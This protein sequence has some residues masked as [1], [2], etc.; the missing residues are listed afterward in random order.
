MQPGKAGRTWR[1][2][3]LSTP[4]ASSSK[5]QGPVAPHF[6]ATLNSSS[7]SKKTT[8]PCFNH[9]ITQTISPAEVARAL[10]QTK[11]HTAPGPDNILQAHPKIRCWAAGRCVPASPP[12]LPDQQHSSNLRCGNSQQL[13][14]PQRTGLRSWRTS[15]LWLSLLWIWR[16]C[17][18]LSKTNSPS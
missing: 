15:D 13:F 16:P 3:I 8:A 14:L 17:R 6:P 1:Q 11:T 12:E 9:F 18:G 2:W 5:S 10:K 4:A 7:D